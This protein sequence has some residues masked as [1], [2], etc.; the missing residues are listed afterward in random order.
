MVTV[1]CTTQGDRLERVFASH[2]EAMRYAVSL[3]SGLRRVRVPI[4]SLT[5]GSLVII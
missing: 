2:G 3:Q 4:L 1:I 5:V